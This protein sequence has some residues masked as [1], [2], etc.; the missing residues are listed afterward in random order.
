MLAG[1]S[2]AQQCLD[3]MLVGASNT[4]GAASSE[5]EPRWSKLVADYLG[6]EEQRASPSCHPSGVGEPCQPGD[7]CNL[8]APGSTTLSWVN[9]IG[10]FDWC[11]GGLDFTGYVVVLELGSNDARPN[12]TGAA[13]T[14]G[15][16]ESWLNLVVTGILDRGAERVV[17][18][19]SP[20]MKAGTASGQTQAQAEASNALLW[21]YSTRV[22][23]RCIQD[24]LVDCGPDLLQ[25]LD[26][27]D[28]EP[29]GLHY[30]NSGMA[31]VAQAVHAHVAPLL[32][33]EE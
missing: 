12:Q 5:F 2:Q 16:Y 3:L 7:V 15:D 20:P 32:D 26:L 17:L 30:D 9:Y 11:C 10:F 27:D 22:A 23:Q 21:Q 31:K 29:D 25:L 28:I 14:M 24:P 18:M 8:G 1:P 13:F 4:C 19:T 6:R 33:C